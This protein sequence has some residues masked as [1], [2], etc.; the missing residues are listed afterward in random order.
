MANVIKTALNMYR[1]R[2]GA[3]KFTLG[4]PEDWERDEN[5]KQVVDEKGHSN[6]IVR[7]HVNV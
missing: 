7:P 2:Y 3:F 5:G 1:D 4:I 6:K